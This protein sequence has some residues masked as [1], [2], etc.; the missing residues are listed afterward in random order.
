MNTNLAKAADLITAYITSNVP[1]NLLGSP[2]M[3]KSD[4]VKQVAESLNLMVIDF[5]LST[6]DPTDLSGI[7]FIHN[8]RSAYM[9]NEAFPLTTDTIPLKFDKD[10]NPVM[11][12]VMDETGNP[13]MKQAS[14]SGWLLFLDE[15]TNAP[16]A[17]QAAAYQLILDRQVGQNKL[18]PAVRI[19]SA[20]NKITDGAAV[21]GEMSTAL[22][23]RMAH[24]NIELHI[25]TWLDWALTASVSHEITS[26]IKFK[27]TELYR[28]DPKAASDTF[29]CPRTWGMADSVLKTMGMQHPDLLNLLSGVLSDG[30]ATEFVNYC[31]NFV[32]LPTYA[33]IVRDPLHTPVPEG[34]STLYA[35]SGSIGAQA[36]KDTVAKVMQYVARMPREFQLRTFNDFTKRDPK[37]VVVTEVRE[38]LTANAKHMIK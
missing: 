27:P 17:V 13:V 7:P 38:W 20:G 32:G 24:I 10:N 31:K 3:G 29:P 9:P 33:D 19:M 2:G 21:T 26:F 5:R 34:M 1:V 25:E 37:L 11:I 28:F 18:H 22:K 6:A 16:M 14:Y 23:S 35:L 36:T 4:V 8:G 12:P 15:I 30:A